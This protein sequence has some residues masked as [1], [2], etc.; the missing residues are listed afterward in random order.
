[1]SRT[2]LLDRLRREDPAPPWWIDRQKLDFWRTHRG[3]MLKILRD[4]E[5]P[6]FSI[7]EIAN[8]YF[9]FEPREY[10]DFHEL[11]GL[12][13]PYG[14]CW[15]EHPLPQTIHSEIGDSD[16]RAL[17]RGE[18]GFLAIQAEIESVKGEGIPA[19]AK[20]IVLLEIFIRYEPVDGGD[21]TEGPLGTWMFALDR[22]GK[23]LTVPSMQGFQDPRHNEHM[24]LYQ[25][26]LWPPLLACS[27]LSIAGLRDPAFL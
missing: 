14:A 26:F 21:R 23:I 16:V 17:T 10:W 11:E 22:A 20:Q 5:L 8:Y 25:S 19:G 15:M 12:Q 18:A 3:G 27:D 4:R 24:K 6:A 2:P 9:A 7:D 1:M 13:V